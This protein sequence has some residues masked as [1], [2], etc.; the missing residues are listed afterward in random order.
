VLIV[1][2]KL[3]LTVLVKDVT[4]LEKIV[5]IYLKIC[6]FSRAHKHSTSTKITPMRKT[7]E[8]N[9]NG[10]RVINTDHLVTSLC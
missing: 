9:L 10:Y 8:D 5:F 3:F 4:F 7:F 1:V 2:E 6:I